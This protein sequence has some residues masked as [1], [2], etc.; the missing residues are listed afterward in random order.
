MPTVK[1]P[2][3]TYRA[4]LATLGLTMRVVLFG[5]GTSW[6]RQTLVRRP[7]PQSLTD[8]MF[9]FVRPEG[10]GGPGQ[11]FNGPPVI[12]KRTRRYLVIHQSG[13]YDV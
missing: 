13:G 12:L 11:Q 9:E 8:L 6:V 2:E 5:D 3:T 10:C 7:L 4:K 1:R